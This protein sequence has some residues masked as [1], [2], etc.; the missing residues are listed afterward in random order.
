MVSEAKSDIANASNSTISS[1]NSVVIDSGLRL[2]REY[3][4]TLFATNVAGL[5]VSNFTFSK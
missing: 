2:G 4:V 1:G 5:S 3:V